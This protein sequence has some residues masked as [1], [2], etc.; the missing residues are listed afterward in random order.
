MNKLIF[1]LPIMFLLFFGCTAQD[2]DTVED[3]KQEV[4]IPANGV[5]KIENVE[6]NE[7]RTTKEQTEELEQREAEPE[8]VDEAVE[9]EP[10]VKD[11]WDGYEQND[12]ICSIKVEKEVARVNEKVQVKT[13]ASAP[14]GKPIT[15]LCGDEE[16][17]IGTGGVRTGSN[18]CEFSEDGKYRLWI[19]IDGK[20][21]NHVDIEIQ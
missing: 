4:E 19:A 14:K 9:E 17:K 15:F 5:G 16:V 18:F 20:P 11:F 7:S 3:A 21:C 1:S 10:I 12:G 2:G 13:W 6:E 8:Q